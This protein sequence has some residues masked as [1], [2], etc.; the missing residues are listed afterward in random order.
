VE[1]VQE[2]GQ[3][4]GECRQIAGLARPKAPSARCGSSHSFFMRCLPIG[5]VEKVVKGWKGVGFMEVIE[6]G[7]KINF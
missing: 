7:E 2:Q 1:V 4:R 5:V 6:N 3:T